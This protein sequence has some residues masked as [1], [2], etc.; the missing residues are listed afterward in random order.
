[1]KKKITATMLMFA[2]AMLMFHAAVPHHHHPGVVVCFQHHHHDCDAHHHHH[3]C[4][5]GTCVISDFFSPSDIQHIDVQVVKCN[6]LDF[7]FDNHSEPDN[8]I[9]GLEGTQFRE[10]PYLFVI[11]ETIMTRLGVLHAPPV[12]C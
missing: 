10:R 3:G 7:Y 12:L 6:F 9:F 2:C 5:E 11:N 1:M 4:D 8:H